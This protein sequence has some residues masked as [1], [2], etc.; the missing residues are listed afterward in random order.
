MQPSSKNPS[1]PFSF[2]SLHSH[3]YSVYN[4]KRYDTQNPNPSNNYWST[5][6]RKYISLQWSN[7]SFSWKFCYCVIIV[8]N[9]S[10][11]GFLCNTEAHN[12][13]LSWISRE[14][15]KPKM[16]NSMKWPVKIALV[17]LKSDY[18]CRSRCRLYIKWVNCIFGEYI[19]CIICTDTFNKLP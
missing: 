3:L 9:G 5:H 16:G 2:A 7:C 19:K 8:P 1:T 11:D 14:Y 13:Q 12:K 10:A 17:S 6:Y 18:V 4:F 15:I